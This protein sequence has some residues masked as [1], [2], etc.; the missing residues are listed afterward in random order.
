M[1]CASSHDAHGLKLT[2]PAPVAGVTHCGP[3]LHHPEDITDFP[4]FPEN[5]RQSLL[6]KALTKEVWEELKD[7]KDASGVSF[8]TCILSGAQNVDSGIGC[9]A[10]SHDSYTTFAPLFDQ[11]VSM[12]HKHGKDAKHVSNMDAT[13]LNCPKLPEDEAAMIVSTRIRVG[14]NLHG[15]PLG[16][17][18]TNEQRIE[19]MTKV[20]EAFKSYTGDLAGNFYALNKLSKKEREQLIADHFLFK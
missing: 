8:K 12:Y 20:T 18:I 19:V 14:R 15:Y 16:P 17:G 2:K 5:Y 4:E 3:W 1:G 13:Q 7:K 11:I 6:C 10:G 9:Y